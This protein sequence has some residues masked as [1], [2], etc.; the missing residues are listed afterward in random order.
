MSYSAKIS[1]KRIERAVEGIS[2]SFNNRLGG[3]CSI[4]PQDQRQ[5]SVEFGRA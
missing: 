5:V 2:L 4:I 1:G 3:K